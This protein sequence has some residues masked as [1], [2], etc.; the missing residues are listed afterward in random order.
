MSSNNPYAPPRVAVRDMADSSAEYQLAGRGVRLV[1]VIFDRLIMGVMIFAPFFIVAFVL[2]GLGDPA[3]QLNGTAV[4]TALAVSSVGLIAWSWITIV[5]VVRNGQTIAKMAMDIKVVRSD[6]S[7][8]SLGRI[9]WLR[10]VVNILLGII[11]FYSLIDSL[12]IFGETRQCVHD[13]LADTIV[14]R[15]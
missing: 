5:N 4:L 9:F 14:V 10:N 13:K 1:A 12:L 11:P 8:V 7:P 2:G 3:G 6:G 15:A